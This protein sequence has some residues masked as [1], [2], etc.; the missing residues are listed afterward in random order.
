MT[1]ELQVVEMN[2]FG[3]RHSHVDQEAL[4]DTSILSIFDLTGKPKEDFTKFVTLAQAGAVSE[5]VNMPYL[6]LDEVGA[7]VNGGGMRVRVRSSTMMI[8]YSAWSSGLSRSSTRPTVE[9]P[10]CE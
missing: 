4:R 2:E 7:T 6:M 10:C 8:T 5:I 3:A 1:P 9:T